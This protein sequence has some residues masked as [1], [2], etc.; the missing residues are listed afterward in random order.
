M[1]KV[2]VKTKDNKI[3]EGVIIHKYKA[4]EG[5]MRYII[6]TD[7]NKEIRCIYDFMPE[8]YVEYNP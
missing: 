4:F 6:K 2:L 1:D 7:D 8:R 5:G 3:V